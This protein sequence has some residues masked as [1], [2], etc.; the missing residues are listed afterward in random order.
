MN[1][2]DVVDL[3]EV[4]ANVAKVDLFGCGFEQDPAGIPQETVGGLEHQGDHDEGGNGVG[5]RVAGGQDDDA[6]D[7]RADEAVEVGE[8]VLEGALH[9]QA[10]S[11]ALGQ[12]HAG[13]DV[14]R[15]ADQGDDQHGKALDGRRV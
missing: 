3:G 15:N 9:V 12:H 2:L 13:G 1:V 10:G 8:D 7:H 4:M 14:D 5:P 11:V 6:G